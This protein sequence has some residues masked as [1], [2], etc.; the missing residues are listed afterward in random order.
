MKDLV[1]WAG[2]KDCRID[3]I[4]HP[5]FRSPILHPLYPPYDCLL[6]ICQMMGGILG[7]TLVKELTKRITPNLS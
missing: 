5:R 1:D 7:I 3:T 6:K 2:V 4:F